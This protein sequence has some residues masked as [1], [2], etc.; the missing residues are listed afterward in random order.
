MTGDLDYC[1]TQFVKSELLLIADLSPTTRN[2][3]IDSYA[4]PPRT[5]HA[6]NPDTDPQRWFVELTNAIS[7]QPLRTL[8]SADPQVSVL[9]AQ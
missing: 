6:R 4:C 2:S 3:R 8:T 5:M 7:D 1:K 9:R